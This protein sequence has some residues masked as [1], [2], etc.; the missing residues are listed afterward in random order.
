MS[1]IFEYISIVPKQEYMGFI[2]DIKDEI[3]DSKDISY[4]AVSLS[5]KSEGIWTHD[6]H[7]K[8]QQKVRIFTN[9]NMLRLSG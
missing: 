2:D 3:N 1:L 4:L 8:E 9:I 7:F 5:Y 6:P